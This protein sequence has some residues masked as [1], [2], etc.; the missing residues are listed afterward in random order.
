MTAE[1]VTDAPK[2]YVHP[3][4]SPGGRILSVVSPPD[5]PW[6]RGL[7]FAIKFVN[8]VNFWEE[9]G[10]HG[11]QVQDGGD[12]AWIDPDGRARLRERRTVTID[13]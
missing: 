10:P 8:D 11:R 6:M 13:E 5:H 9:A 1:Y 4:V 2:P 3:L 12:V 7:W